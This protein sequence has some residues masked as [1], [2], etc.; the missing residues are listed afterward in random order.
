MLLRARPVGVKDGRS[1]SQV[2]ENFE[3]KELTA[4]STNSEIGVTSRREKGR[5]EDEGCVFCMRMYLH[6]SGNA[7]FSHIT[8]KN[9]CKMR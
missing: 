7:P 5:E 8:A 2:S 4:D 9:G 1:D 3:T 6:R